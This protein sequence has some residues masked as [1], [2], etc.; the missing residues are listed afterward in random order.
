M[1]DSFNFDHS[2]ELRKTLKIQVLEFWTILELFDATCKVIDKTCSNQ[3]NM[4]QSCYPNK[5]YV[6]PFYLLKLKIKKKKIYDQIYSFF[7]YD[8][9]ENSFLH[10]TF[11]YKRYQ[12]AEALEQFW[13]HNLRHNSP[14]WRVVV[15]KEVLVGPCGDTPPPTITR[16]IG[17]LCHK[18]WHQT[19]SKLW[20]EDKQDHN[21]V[22]QLQLTDLLE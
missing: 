6:I 15:G 18:L 22:V 2:L 10:N 3:L 9:Q 19:F 1:A 20:E 13:W 11:N 4:Q 8:N 7:S 16:H 12:E 17:K 5:F 14:M 21:D